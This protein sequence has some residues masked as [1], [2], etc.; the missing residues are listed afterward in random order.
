M[1]LNNMGAATA[2]VLLCLVVWLLVVM[3]QFFAAPSSPV[4]VRVFQIRSNTT[5]ADILTYRVLVGPV[6]DADVV[7][8]E[9]SVYVDGSDVAR[10]V[11]AYEPS[12]TELGDVLVA[13]GSSV[14]LRVV[15]IDDAGNRSEPAV[16]AFV[17]EDTLPPAQPGTL[18][19]TLVSETKGEEPTA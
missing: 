3:A 9:L 1:S 19:V 7:T 10:E 13:Q 14:E 17:A 16:L 12:A 11:R 18:G 15:D 4:D 6:V 2:A 5:M 8:R